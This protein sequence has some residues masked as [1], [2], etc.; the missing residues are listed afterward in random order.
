[1][2]PN[3][4]FPHKAPKDYSYEF[5]Q[6]N[7]STIR[8]M[9]RCNRK[10]DYNLGASTATVWGFYKPKKQV[11]YAPVNAKSIGKQIDIENTT[12]YSAMPIK[13]T[14]LEACFV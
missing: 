8:I 13:R 14:T 6:F 1:M 5:E 3:P 7:A 11:Y 12:A 10:F 4:E 9:L 2:N